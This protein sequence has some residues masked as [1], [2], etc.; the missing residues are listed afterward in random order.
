MVPAMWK[1]TIAILIV[2]A[3]VVVFANILL[4]LLRV[5]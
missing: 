5:E 2:A 4:L 1:H 3:L